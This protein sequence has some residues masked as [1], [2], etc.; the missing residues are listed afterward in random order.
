MPGYD[1][2]DDTQTAVTAELT[3]FALDKSNNR[4]QKKVK[5]KVA[6]TENLVKKDALQFEK[7]RTNLVEAYLL[8]DQLFRG[9]FAFNEASWIGWNHVLITC[10]LVMA[11][12][13]IVSIVVS[14]LTL[15]K[16]LRV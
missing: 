9:A 13:L 14:Y 10:G 11:I 6:D 7:Y 5:I 1:F 12:G 3:F 15:L 16:Y 8:I 2:V 4:T